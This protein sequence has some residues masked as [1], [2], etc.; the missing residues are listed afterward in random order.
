MLHVVFK[1]LLLQFKKSIFPVKL[2]TYEDL[3]EFGSKNDEAFTFKLTLLFS[4][5]SVP[6]FPG[7][8]PLQAPSG[9][10]PRLRLPPINIQNMQSYFLNKCLLYLPRVDFGLGLGVQ[11]V[12]EPRSKDFIFSLASNRMLFIHTEHLSSN[13]SASYWGRAS[14]REI[15]LSTERFRNIWVEVVHFNNLKLEP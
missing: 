15:A 4:L 12:G 6:L 8:S 2:L 1:N 14:F 10:S 5:Q 13:T 3:C 9:E 11:Q 7:I